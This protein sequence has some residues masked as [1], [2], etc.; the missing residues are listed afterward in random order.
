MRTICCVRLTQRPRIWM[1]GKRPPQRTCAPDDDMNS[2]SC[3]TFCANHFL[4]FT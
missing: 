3:N 2:S 4:R 1:V